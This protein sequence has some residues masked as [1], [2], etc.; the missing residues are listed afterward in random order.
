MGHYKRGILVNT[1]T[2]AEAVGLSLATVRRHIR[3]G[4]VDMGD[5]MSVVRYVAEVRI[6]GKG[7]R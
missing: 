1:R 2:L 7:G 5:L 4:K 6:I 3:D